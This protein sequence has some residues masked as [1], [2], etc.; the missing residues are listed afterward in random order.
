M[1][2]RGGGKVSNFVSNPCMS[3][4]RHY[5]GDGEIMRGISNFGSRFYCSMSPKVA[6]K[7]FPRK[8]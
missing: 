1:I 3:I 6:E 5:F 8:A 7:V 4:D 2:Q